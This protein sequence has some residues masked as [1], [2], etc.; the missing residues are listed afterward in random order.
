MLLQSVVLI[1]GIDCLKPEFVN[2]IF[3][4]SGPT[5]QEIHYISIYKDRPINDVQ[6]NNCCLLRESNETRKYTLWKKF[7]VSLMLKEVSAVF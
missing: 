5:S 3:S 7:A 1:K 6:G 4:N 2:I